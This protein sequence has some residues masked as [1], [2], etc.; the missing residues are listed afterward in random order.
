MKKILIVSDSHGYK[1]EVSAL[2]ASF[3]DNVDVM[4]HCGDSELDYDHKAMRVFSKKV[5]G[6][7]DYDLEYPDEE[8]FSVGG[9]TFY[10]AHGHNHGVK[11]SFDAISYRA[12]EAGAQIVCHGHSHLA[13]ATKFGEQ[14]IINPGS[15]RLPRGRKEETYAILELKDS[16]EV[17]VRFYQL[18]GKEVQ[19]LAFETTMKLK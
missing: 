12:S 8:I 2:T 11:M 7:C 9:F 18:D 10:V 16:Q 14:L 15:I 1:K 13:H 4:V 19:S 3:E 6:N 5:A 17:S